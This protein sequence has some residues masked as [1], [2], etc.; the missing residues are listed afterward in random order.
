MKYSYS[1]W[2]GV[3]RWAISPIIGIITFSAGAQSIAQAALLKNTIY[4]MDFISD[5][6]QPML[7]EKILL[8]GN[9]NTLAT[10][11]IFHNILETRPATLYMLGDVVALGFSNGKWRKVD[12]FLDSCKTNGTQVYGLLGNHDVMGQAKKGER[13]FQKRFPMHIPTG[14]VTV[15]DSVAVILLN[16]NFT[17]ITAI[18]RSNQLKWYR[19]LLDSLDRDS[20]IKTIIVTCHHAPYTNSTV[21]KPST[22]VQQDFVLP[23]LKSSKAKLFITGH[24]HAFEHFNVSG[25]NFLVIGGGGGLHQPL[26][27]KPNGPYDLASSYKPMFHYL[28]IKRGFNKLIVT[29]IYVTPDF[30]KLVSGYNFLIDIST[31]SSS[32]AALVSH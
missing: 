19:K 8:P 3:L 5:T 21:V 20:A 31:N 7:M 29:S 17:K 6:Q 16:S 23:Y 11:M 30:S 12:A 18:N 27:P 26:S 10:S 1:R 22:I 4:E 28:S 24:S 13:N 9:H 2:F 14:Y 32:K 15:T 25:K